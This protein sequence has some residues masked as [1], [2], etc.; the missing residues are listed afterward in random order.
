MTKEL[1]S[2]DLLRKLLRYE[3]ETG[4]LFWRERDREFFKSDRDYKVWNIRFAG[5]EAFTASDCGYKTGKVFGK[6]YR[7]HRIIWALQT[8]AWPRDE[9]DH[10]DQ[11]KSNNAWELFLVK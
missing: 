11:D 5:K 4:K 8:G 9:I 2:P 7:A 6:T 10:I 3:P 1:P